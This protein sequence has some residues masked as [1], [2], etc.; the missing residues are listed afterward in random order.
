MGVRKPNCH[1]IMSYTNDLCIDEW[2]PR[3]ASPPPMSYPPQN[4]V[5]LLRPVHTPES[6]A[7]LVPNLFLPSLNT[8]FVTI[9][10]CDQCAEA[11]KNRLMRAYKD[12]STSCLFYMCTKCTHFN[13]VCQCHVYQKI[14]N[15]Q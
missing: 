9:V 14:I 5:P 8:G 7:R 2:M 4:Q 10:L 15:K 13:S 6:K 11:S 12:N 3:T 1:F